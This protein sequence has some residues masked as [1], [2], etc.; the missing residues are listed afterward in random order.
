MLFIDNAAEAPAVGA[1]RRLH[2]SS[3][4]GSSSD[5]V[6]TLLHD[7]AMQ[8]AKRPDEAFEF[9]FNPHALDAYLLHHCA[10]GLAIDLVLLGQLLHRPG[11]TGVDATSIV[12]RA[13]SDAPA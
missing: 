6:L 7:H 1:E 4:T 5:E 10:Y 11:V 12:E 3:P 9:G 8:P 13:A 2:S